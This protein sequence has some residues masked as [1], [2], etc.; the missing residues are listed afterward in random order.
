MYHIALIAPG[1]EWPNQVAMAHYSFS[2]FMMRRVPHPQ[3]SVWCG[4]SF[5]FD[6]VADPLELACV[7]RA[8]SLAG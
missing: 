2:F 4:F 3:K 5:L 6:R 7:I 8:V 1:D